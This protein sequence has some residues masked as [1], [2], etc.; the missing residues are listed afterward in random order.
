MIKILAIDDNPDN[1]TSLRAI[2]KDTF[3]EAAVITALNGPKGI[4]LAQADNPDVVL[5]DIVMPD[6]DG[7]AVC[8]KLKSAESTRDIPVIFLTALKTDRQ[9]RIKA[10]E[11]GAEGFLGKPLDETE[12]MAQVR[13]MVKIKAAN[14]LKRNESKHL[15]ALVAG[16]T[17]ELQKE[18][19]ERKQ[20]ENEAIQAQTFS[21]FIIDSIPGAFYMLDENGRYVRWNAYQRDEIIGKPENMVAG[22]NAID[23][24][25][26]D[27]RALIQSKIENVIANGAIETVEGR[28]LLRGGPAFR[29]LLM[30][31][32][33]MMIDGRPF[34]IGIG[35]DITERKQAESA[36]R[37]SEERYKTLANNIPDVIYSLDGE[38]NIVTVNR[39]AFE[40]YGYNEQ[41]FKG[42]PFL[43]FVHPEDREI[44]ISSFLKAIEEKRKITTGLQFRIAAKNGSNRWFE[45]NASARFDSCGRYLGEEGMLRDITDRKQAEESLRESEACFR[46]LVERAPEGIFVQTGGHFLFVNPAMVKLLGV[47]D[48][49]D[50]IGTKIIERIAPEYHQAVRDRIRVQLQTSEPASPMEQEYLRIDGSRI[51]VET[52]AIP[53]RF[54]GQDAHLVFVRDISARLKAKAQQEKLHEQL[55][56]AQKMEAIGRLA[57]G[58]AHDF[59]NMLN[60][61]IGYSEMAVSKLHA[62][63][64]LYPDIQEVIGAA[65]RSAE[66][67]RQLLAFSRKQV[68]DPQVIDLNSQM[69]GMERLLKRII[70]EDISLKFELA[71]DLWPVRLDPSQ[72]DQI[73]ANLAVNSR[74]AMPDGG[75]L[76]METCNTAIDISYAQT[77]PHFQPGEYV[78]LAVSDSGCGMNK[79]TLEHVFEP[80]FTTKAEGKGTGLGLAMVYGIVKQ[81]NGFINI[82]SEPGQGTTIR[83]YFQRYHGEKETMQEKLIQT[84]AVGGRETILLVEDESQLRRL[85]E[86]ML[87]RLGYKVL[88]AE[89]PGAAILLVE[90]FDETIHLLLTDV[91]MPAMNGKELAKRID[92]IKPGIKVLFMSGYTANAIAHRGVLD[93][94]LHFLQKP[95]SRNQLAKAVREALAESKIFA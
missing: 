22:T 88:E 30:T 83:I 51:Q 41:D 6:M 84:E 36:L 90:K 35:I 54:L 20:A 29:W 53:L 11:A 60:V 64:P 70:G 72:V 31:G 1:L 76:T 14:D 13:S 44:L 85:A 66:L 86:T 71:K 55:Q 50:L 95:F 63:D 18:L 48:A 2:L 28:V 89:S 59:N 34:L 74:D 93:K 94:G 69:K 19:G 7:F 12:L 92:A 56:Q 78:L 43:D 4:E 52:T 67:T 58:M 42:K 17:R 3:P 77:H 38:G 47:A 80:F 49:D 87:E 62:S 27:D 75:T 68:I 91:V 32:H 26:S 21:K 37:E 33:R 82:Y 23:T 46:I 61:I 8:R 9:N 81:N 5:L 15:A 24:I 73:V 40:S 25:H 57:G 16:R 45:L 10:L 79:D 39:T 65:N